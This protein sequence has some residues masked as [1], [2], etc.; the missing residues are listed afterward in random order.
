MSYQLDYYIQLAYENYKHI[1][2]LSFDEFLIKFRYLSNLDEQTLHKETS[3][4]VYIQIYKFIQD[5]L[6]TSIN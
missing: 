3:N 1:I 5:K 4:P 6:K 2:N